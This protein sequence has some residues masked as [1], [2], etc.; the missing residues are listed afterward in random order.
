MTAVLLD[1]ICMRSFVLLSEW[2]DVLA[3]KAAVK[4]ETIAEIILKYQNV[5]A[6]T[7]MRS[8]QNNCLPTCMEEAAASLRAG[9]RIFMLGADSAGCMGIIDAS[10]MPDTYGSPFDQ[11]RG[12]V[13][14]GWSSEG[15]SNVTGDISDC[16]SLHKISFADFREDILPTLSRSDSVII[17][18]HSNCFTSELS[19]LAKEVSSLSSVFFIAAVHNGQQTQDTEEMI[20]SLKLLAQSS[21]IIQLSQSQEGYFDYSLK[22]ML[23][24]ISTYAQVL[25]P[26][27]L[28][29]MLFDN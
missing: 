17:V 1:A 3:L 26:F 13:Q 10:E 27:V 8:F 9:G 5:H 22:L 23:N 11:I 2:I 14:G 28:F 24:A 4:S 25:Q 20:K 7:Y 29:Y 12:F 6:M 16:S 15:V 19:F 18:A 21:V